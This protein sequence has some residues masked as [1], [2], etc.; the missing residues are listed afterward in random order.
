[1]SEEY[2]SPPAY[3]LGRV[4]RLDN[5]NIPLFVYIV[6]VMVMAIM[7]LFMINGYYHCALSLRRSS[8]STVWSLLP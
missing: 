2:P 5:D 1:M 8:L 7:M 6:M 4:R 3:L